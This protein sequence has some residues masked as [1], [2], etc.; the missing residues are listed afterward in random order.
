MKI[1]ELKAAVL[2][3]DPGEQKRFI[4]ELLTEIMPKVCTDDACLDK[5]RGFID[6]ETIKNYR[7]QHMDGI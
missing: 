2:Q 7:A 4:L 5:I 1:E 6:E 3:L